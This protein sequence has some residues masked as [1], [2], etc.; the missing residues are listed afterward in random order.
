VT[1]SAQDTEYGIGW[2]IDL[3]RAEPMAWPPHGYP[4]VMV[5]AMEEFVRLKGAG[6]VMPAPAARRKADV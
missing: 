6:Q 2:L 3:A 1:P 5:M 4:V